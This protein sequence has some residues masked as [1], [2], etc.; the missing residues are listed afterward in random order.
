[1]RQAIRAIADAFIYVRISD[2][3][4]TALGVKRQEDDCRRD[5]ARRQWNVLRVFVDNDVS[6]STGKPRPAYRRM[7]AALAEGQAQAVI[8]WD[9]DRLY[10]QPIELEEFIALAD[11]HGILLASIGGDVDLSTP[12]GRLVARMKG[13]VARHEVEQLSRRASRKKLRRFRDCTR[14]R[15]PLTGQFGLR[16]GEG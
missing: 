10:R 15:W 13:A 1:M 9:L 11:R 4:G 16:A 7:L 12:Q 8:V 14:N 3:D 6:A 5:A 2:D